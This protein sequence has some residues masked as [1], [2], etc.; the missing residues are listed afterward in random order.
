MIR[1]IMRMLHELGEANTAVERPY[2]R[3]FEVPFLDATLKYYEEES[4]RNISSMSGACASM[5]RS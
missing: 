4:S 3:Y 5:F 1:Q 2:K